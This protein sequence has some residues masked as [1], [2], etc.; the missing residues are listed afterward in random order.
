MKGTKEAPGMNRDMKRGGKSRKDMP[1]AGG[2][3]GASGR[4]SK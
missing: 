3:M 4:S 1:Q 2:G